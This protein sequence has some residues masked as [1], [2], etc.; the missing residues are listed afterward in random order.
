MNYDK[1]CSCNGTCHPNNARTVSPKFHSD[2][3]DE[4]DQCD[5]LPKVLPI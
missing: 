2:S 3:L 1:V 4:K 5:S